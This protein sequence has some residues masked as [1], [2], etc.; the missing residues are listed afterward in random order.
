MRRARMSD[1]IVRGLL[2]PLRWPNGRDVY[3]IL[4]LPLQ[5]E[6]EI[7]LLP[8]GVETI[9]GKH[10]GEYPQFV[11]FVAGRA[12]GVGG[13]EQRS[14]ALDRGRDCRELLHLRTEFSEA[15]AAPLQVDKGLSVGIIIR[16]GRRV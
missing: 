8:V 12:V 7:A 10:A 13:R 4:R 2:T 16:L 6:L 14:A 5:Q 15:S 11:R 3:E 9:H 1:H